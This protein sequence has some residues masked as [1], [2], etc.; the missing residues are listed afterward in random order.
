MALNQLGLGMIFTAQDMASGVMGKIRTGFMQTRNEMGQFTLGSKRLELA[1]ANMG[2]GAAAFGVGVAGMAAFGPAIVKSTQ[3][4]AS[5]A[6][7]RTVADEASLSFDQMRETTMGLAAT[8]G[9]DAIV[10]A[11]ALYETISA[12]VTDVGE[13]TRLLETA[14][15]FAVGGNAEMAQSIDVLTSAVN[16]YREKGL[17]AA[18]ASDIMFTAIAAGKTTAQQLSQYLGEVAPTAEA[19]GVSF[20]ELNGAIATLTVL[21][22]RTPQ[23]VTGLNAML[24]N[25]MKPSEDAKKEA[26]RLGI[27]FDATALKTMGLK[28]VLA[29][30]AGNTKVNNNTMVELFGSIDGI[31]VAL[32]LA[33]NGGSK[34][35]E[36]LKQMEK[37]S[38]ATQKAFEIMS[39]TAKFQGERFKALATN[40]LLNVGQ[41]LDSI[42]ARAIGF[43][44]AILEA[45]NSIPKPIRDAAVR[46]VFLTSAVI[47]LVGAMTSM[48]AGLT[49]A[50]AG[51]KAFGLSASGSFVGALLPAAIALGALTLAFY[52][53]KQAYDKNLGGFGDFVDGAFSKVKLAFSALGQLFT[54][55]G[56]SGEVAK[57]FEKGNN[58]VLNFAI[59]VYV[60]VG[61]V[62]GFLRGLGEG[63]S[64]ALEAGKAAFQELG[65]NLGGLGD[66]LGLTS[67][68]VKGNKKAFDDWRNA[69]AAVGKGLAKLVTGVVQVVNAVTSAVKALGGWETILKAVEAILVVI[70]VQRAA[71]FAG[72]MGKMGLAA[73]GIVSNLFDVSKGVDAIDGSV[74]KTAK[75]SSKLGA[76]GS[77]LRGQIGAAEA[78]S[79]A[80]IAVGLAYDQYEKLDKE[81]GKSGWDDMKNKL[82]NDLGIDSDAEYQRKLGINS[83]YDKEQR[84]IAAVGGAPLAVATDMSKTLRVVPDSP[85]GSPAVASVRP[86]G[87]DAEATG[88]AVASA[89]AKVKIPAPR[90]SVIVQ[91]DGEDIPSRSTQEFA[92]GGPAD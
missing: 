80:I 60:L 49:I 31:K 38:G 17:T 56:F 26:K 82:R 14:N 22:V 79:A 45:F 41:A 44:N 85:D 3:Y 90:T 61:R 34:F 29:Q 91:V 21:G 30:L 81:L 68:G 6:N 71:A 72:A 16:V 74:A 32:A 48:R 65:A 4:E 64:A 52:A 39:K 76:I 84:G 28:G 12:G 9:K 78:L 69:G 77:N 55:G 23:A 8:Y 58:P 13:A 83:G 51:L 5:L 62:K 42:K 86:G 27:Q 47:A 25:L 43:G 11:D 67:V 1:F 63:F 88:Q 73:A 92:P 89:V 66:A 19:A 15:K 35:H 75:G 7:I 24:S 36:V 37:S 40:S 10:Q 18:Q 50:S 57:E 46:V 59:Q 53:F 33:K 20:A 70:A 2:R 54:Q 87:A